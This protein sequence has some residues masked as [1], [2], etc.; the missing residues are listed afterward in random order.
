MNGI[1]P[2]REHDIYELMDI[3]HPD[4]TVDLDEYLQRVVTKSLEW[5]DASGI[6]I[7]VRDG[8][9]DVFRLAKADGLLSKVP[10]DATIHEGEGI[11]GLAIA[12][13]TARLLKDPRTEQDLIE[14]GIKKNEAIG[15]SLIVPLATRNAG[16]IGVLNVARSVETGDFQ[17]TDLEAAEALGRQLALAVSNA[18]SFSQMATKTQHVMRAIDQ[19]GFGLML[20]GQEGEFIDFTSECS[21]ILQSRPREHLTVNTYL[22]TISPPFQRPLKLGLE[23]AQKGLNYRFR[24]Q[25]DTRGTSYAVVTSPLANGGLVVAIHDIT[26]HEKAREAYDRIRRLAEIGQMTASIAHELRNPLAGI[27]SAATMIL[28]DPLLATEFAEIIDREAIKL[29]QL[30]G[31]FLEFAKP[32]S[33]EYEPIKISDI[34]RNLGVTHAS[35]F[36]KQHVRLEVKSSG[37][38]PVL[39]ADPL[40]IEQVMR[41]LILNALEASTSGQTVTVEIDSY[42]VVKIQDQGIGMEPHVVDRLFTPFFTTKP[43]GTGLGLSMCQ[44]IMEAHK[45][46]ISVASTPGQGTT[47]ELNFNSKNAA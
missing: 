20:I 36:E 3:A 29:N 11:A 28:E 24:V 19:V 2:V 18:R 41:N 26:D 47:V 38:E 43:S 40:R 5:F 13:Q 31:T 1:R 9:T 25:D 6:S 42:G 35:E 17:E 44:K 39:F 12:E 4:G 46:K 30:C 10:K 37:D 21:T 15:S 27:R 33:L 23:R 14:K 34:A 7:F 32:I 16:C 45:S 8:G 22:P